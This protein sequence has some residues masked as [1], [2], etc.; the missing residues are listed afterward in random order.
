MCK[1]WQFLNENDGLIMALLTLIMVSLNFLQWK[2]THKLQREA[3]RPKV[4]ANVDGIS[5]KIYYKLVNFGTTSAINV[6]V[7]IDARVKNMKQKGDPLR[8]KLERIEQ[9]TISILPNSTVFIP[10]YELWNKLANDILLLSYTYE[11]LDGTKY[12][13]QYSFDLAILDIIETKNH[14]E[15]EERRRKRDITNSLIE[16]ANNLTMKNRR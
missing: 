1:I 12:S 9:S 15:Q 6:H 3:N 13:E 10:T 7:T 14:Y 16:I 5:N 2:L 4:M 8:D 11:G